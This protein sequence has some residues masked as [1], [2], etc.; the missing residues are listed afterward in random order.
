MSDKQDFCIFCIWDLF[1]AIKGLF[2]TI[3]VHIFQQ[4]MKILWF[5]PPKKYFP[6]GILRPNLPFLYWIWKIL[7]FFT[8]NHCGTQISL[9]SWTMSYC[10]R[11]S[12]CL[13]GSMN[14]MH[15]IICCLNTNTPAEKELSDSSRNILF[16]Y[17]VNMKK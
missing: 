1:W 11:R 7:T 4:K 2:F 15:H 13:Q 10:Q 8:Q 3:K 6:I 17:Q 16:P 14:N 12:N 5:F 9:C